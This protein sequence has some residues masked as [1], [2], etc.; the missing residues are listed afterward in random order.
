LPAVAHFASISCGLSP[1]ARAA[2]TPEGHA[3]AYCDWSAQE[4]GTAAVVF[5]DNPMWEAY[6]TGDPHITFARKIGRAPAHATKHTHPAV[7]ETMNFGI[8]YG[9]T[10]YGLARRANISVMA[11]EDL[12]RRHKALHS[13]YWRRSDLFVDKAMLGLPLSTRLGW[14]LQYPPNSHAVASPRTAQNYLVQA[15]ASEMMRCAAI[16]ATEAGLKVC[17][18]VHDA[19]L[20][21]APEAEINDAAA[22]LVRI[23]GDASEAV[24]GAGRRLRADMKIRRWPQPYLETRGLE[25]FNILSDELARIESYRSS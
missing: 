8:L 14:T 19:F 6:V 25:L 21:E 16:R 7:R 4:Y 24:L 20:L 10:G 3:I 23:M 11:A 13:E 18:P 17:C 15:N 1:C 2:S 9:M 5:G 22:Q 12:I